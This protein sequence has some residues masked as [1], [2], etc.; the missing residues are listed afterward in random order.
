M[1]L[2]NCMLRAATLILAF[3]TYSNSS[4]VHVFAQEEQGGDDDQQQLETTTEQEVDQQEQINPSPSKPNIVLILADDV[5]TGDIPFYWPGMEDQS[6]VAMPHLQALAN[7]GV[8]F[9]DAHSTPLCAPSR[10]MVL[11]GNYPHRGSSM[12]GTWN[13]ATDENQF[14]PYQKSIAEVLANNGYGTGMFGKWHL[15]SFFL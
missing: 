15:V 1:Y 10:Y 9:K 12:G 4:I 5:G 8:L 13:L 14:G 3:Q 6:K 7:K 11:S 2:P